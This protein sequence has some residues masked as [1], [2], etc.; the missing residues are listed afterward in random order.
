MTRLPAAALL[1]LGLAL[2][3]QAFDM[4]AMSEAER[5]LFRAEVRSYL[6]ENPEV[7][8]EA[9]SVLEQRQAEAQT[10][11]DETLVQ[12]NASE[13]F[14]DGHS[15]V[16]GNPEGDVTLV[17]FVDYR[18]GYCR[19]AHDEVAELVASD[20]NIRLIMKEFPILG[21]QSVL[22]ARF[23]V[24]TLQIAGPDAYEKAHDA[25][26]TFRGNVTEDSLKDL[27]ATLGIDGAAILARMT[28][29]EVDA[30]L[31]SNQS[32][33]QRMQISGT[34]TFIVGPQMLRG[35]MPLDGMRRIVSE[36]REN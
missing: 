36:I 14:E 35:Y 2:P 24:A 25:L 9:I 29:P 31:A 30:V 1:S 21:E 16:G 26:I 32:L 34:P 20:G 19:K 10:A 33:A 23:A 11:N 5:E 22:S 7:L 18:C 8:M 28:A 27:A 17:E 6:L 4:A 15:W 12:V 13:I 3:A